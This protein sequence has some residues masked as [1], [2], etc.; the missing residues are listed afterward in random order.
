MLSKHVPKLLTWQA[1]QHVMNHVANCW[2]NCPAAAGLLSTLP[3]GAMAAGVHICAAHGSMTYI[4]WATAGQC[5]SYNHIYW[6]L[7]PLLQQTLVTKNTEKN[8]NH[9]KSHY[10]RRKKD[11][12]KKLP[13]KTIERKIYRVAVT[14]FLADSDNWILHFWCNHGDWCSQ[15]WIASKRQWKKYEKWKFQPFICLRNG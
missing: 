3:L 7:F 13:I 10:K 6:S 1:M 5:M 2:C 4:C 15:H 9:W 14:L 12:N 8:E 11:L